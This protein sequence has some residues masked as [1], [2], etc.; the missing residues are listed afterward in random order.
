MELWLRH[1]SRR[2]GSPRFDEAAMTKTANNAHASLSA[3]NHLKATTIKK[4]E[5][6]SIIYIR[7]FAE[8]KGKLFTVDGSRVHQRKR[9]NRTFN[10]PFTGCLKFYKRPEWL[11]R[12]ISEY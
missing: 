1:N 12:H 6:E 11:K 8:K 2:Q 3:T 5:C 10:A 7:M 9:S 4:V